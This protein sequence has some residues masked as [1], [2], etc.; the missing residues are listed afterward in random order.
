[1]QA[2][3][4]DHRRRDDAHRDARRAARDR[5]EKPCALVRGE[6]LRVVQDRERPHLVVA[7]DVVVEEDGR[8]HERPGETSA[9]GLVGPGDEARPEPAIEIEELPAR[10]AHG[11]EDSAWDRCF[12]RT[13]A[14][15]PTLERR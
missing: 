1:M 5:A 3:G 12:S 7:Q 2:V 8:G 9:P 13:R 14:F 10:L 4:V 11:P 15:F 6:L